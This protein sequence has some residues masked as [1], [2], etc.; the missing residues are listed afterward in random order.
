MATQFAKIM[1]KTV[2]AYLKL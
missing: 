1:K 2:T